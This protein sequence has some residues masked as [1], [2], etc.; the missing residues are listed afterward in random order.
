MRRIFT[1][2]FIALASIGLLTLFPE[3]NAA[4][5]SAENLSY[6]IIAQKGIQKDKPEYQGYFRGRPLPDEKLGKQLEKIGFKSRQVALF[7]PK[8]TLDFLKKFNVVILGAGGEGHQRALFSKVADDNMK[9]VLEYVKQG[10]SLLV[11]RNPGWQFGKDI[12]EYN[13]WL[14]PTGIKILPEQIV[15]PGNMIT[16]PS[17]GKLFWT[18]NISKHQITE[19]VEGLFYPAIRSKGYRCYTDFSSPVEVNKSWTILARGGK[20]SKSV[21]NIRSGQIH[22]PKPGTFNTAPPFLAVREYGKGRIAVMPL[23]SSVYWHDCYHFFWENLPMEGDYWGMKGNGAKLMTNLFSWLAA[24]SA[25]KFGNYIPKPIPKKAAELGFQRINWDR[26]KLKGRIPEKVCVSGLIGPQSSL[27]GGKGTP[28]EFIKAAKEAGYGFIGFAEHLE[29]MTPEK[30]SQLQKICAAA[31]TGK[32]KAYPG[33]R[34]IDDSGNSW[35][36]FSDK[37]TWAQK[38][39]FSKKYPG[40]LAVNNPL[41]RGWKWPPLIFLHPN[42]NPEP[43]WAQGNF[44]S[45]AVFTYGKDGKLIDDATSWYFRMLKNSFWF[46][47]VAVNLIDSPDQ[48][49]ATRKNKFQTMVRWFDNNVIDGMSRPLRY[50][51]KPVWAFNVF[52]S[53]GPVF[54]DFQIINWGCTDLAIPA[55]DRF[56]MHLKARDPAGLTQVELFDGGKNLLRRFLPEKSKD[57]DETIDFYHDQEYRFVATLTDSKGRRAFSWPLR[58][59]TQENQFPRCS[60][61]FNTMPRGKWWGQPKG[62]H[63]IRGFEDYLVVRNF[64]YFGFPLLLGVD[65]TSRMAV[66]YHPLMVSRF[67]TIVDAIFENH[68]PKSARGNPDSTDKAAATL[69]NE[70]ITG[71]TR[72]TYFTCRQSGSLIELVEGNYK[73]LKDFSTRSACVFNT[74]G[75]PKTYGV[76]A[77][78]DNGEFFAGQL[79]KEKRYFG[80]KLKKN[81]FAA[82]FPCR[83]R[84]SLAAIPLQDGLSFS[85]NTRPDMAYSGLRLYLDPAKKNYKAGEELNFKYIGVVSQIDPAPDNSFV[86]DII[87]KL[88]IDGRTAY[89]VKPTQGKV[90]GNMFILKLQAQDYGFSGRFSQAKLPLSLPVEISGL[91]PNWDAG[92]LYKGKK[93]LV[94]PCWVVNEFSER[95]EALRRRR[96]TNEIYHFTVDAKGTAYLQVDTEVGAKNVYIGNLLICD[97]PEVRLTLVDT[98]PGKAAFVAHNPTD[99]AVTCSVKPGKGFSLFGNFAKDVTIPAGSSVKV[100]IPA[101]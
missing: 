37:L 44:T 55:N 39:W 19:G 12:D 40:R 6:L 63:N 97:N 101:K 45:M 58:T 91:N 64:V 84:G 74:V 36:T 89:S 62:L 35:I 1:A 93:T 73:V 27:S 32:F 23:A 28:E 25:G 82:L 8:L 9:T 88:G 86:Y 49:A 47:P 68:Y 65:E 50:K 52:V 75:Y 13:Q 90:T 11:M 70:Y 33:F 80:G 78:L 4:D 67:G 48:V 26:V 54:D 87:N 76:A 72:Y 16:L 77:T 56:R 38:G 17:N 92:I 46:F 53:E 51:G 79:T 3:I 98:R 42:K 34:Y 22:E 60:D 71:R 96:L 30:F 15:D 61:N 43:P 100:G 2:G 59:A 5:K 24:P 14:K 41:A 81:G 21:F 57:F 94:V 10:G 66:E 95:Y 31:S 99:K 83:F 7:S 85:A 20:S 18:K 29:N 69:K